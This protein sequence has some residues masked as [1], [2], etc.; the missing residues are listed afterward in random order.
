MMQ[1]EALRSPGSGTAAGRRIAAVAAEGQAE[2]GRVGP[3]LM[4]GPATDE[5]GGKRDRRSWDGGQAVGGKHLL[6][7]A[8]AQDVQGEKAGV[9][10][11]R[12]LSAWWGQDSLKVKNKGHD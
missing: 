3:Y 5:A 6:R 8:A 1:Q 10:Q 9:A 2:T 12:G 11:G 7:L 4:A